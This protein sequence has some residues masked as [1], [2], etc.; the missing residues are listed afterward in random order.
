MRRETVEG[1]YRRFLQ[2]ANVE[3]DVWSGGP[4]WIQRS[5][6]DDTGYGRAR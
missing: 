6:D 1:R 5:R 4:E 3:L 2:P